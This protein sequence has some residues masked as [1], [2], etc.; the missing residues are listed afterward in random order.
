[1]PVLLTRV[2]RNAVIIIII[3]I[4]NHRMMAALVTLVTK[5]FRLQSPL[6]HKDFVAFELQECERHRL[7][8]EVKGTLCVC[9]CVC[10]CV[11][12][13]NNAHSLHLS[14]RV[15]KRRGGPFISRFTEL[16]NASWEE[17]EILRGRVLRK[18]SVIT[19]SFEPAFVPSRTHFFFFLLWHRM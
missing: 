6:K 4:I 11:F 5:Y 16:L 8:E 14:Q 1:M 2:K 7:C 9:V 19:F 12:L 15:D 10:V 13:L 18:A 17:G 3:I